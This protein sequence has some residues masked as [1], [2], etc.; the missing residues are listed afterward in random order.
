[1]FPTAHCR[2]GAVTACLD[3][4]ECSYLFSDQDRL[5]IPTLSNI[6][7]SRNAFAKSL[8]ETCHKHSRHEAS[9]A[10]LYLCMLIFAMQPQ[11]LAW[12]RTRT[13]I[14]AAINIDYSMYAFLHFSK[15]HVP[16]AQTFLHNM[17]L[18]RRGL[19]FP[20]GGSQACGQSPHVGL[21][22]SR[23]TPDT[24]P[25]PASISPIAILVNFSIVR[26]SQFTL[27]RIH[28]P[29]THRLVAFS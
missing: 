9:S 8:C 28:E 22:S 3:P 20:R 1:V 2:H 29:Q 6:A 18:P 17:C 12:T 4:Y 26:R 11:Q 25:P 7:H 15:S 27:E 10:C 16:S 23:V 24:E 19:L 5:R 14:C 13:H 21:S